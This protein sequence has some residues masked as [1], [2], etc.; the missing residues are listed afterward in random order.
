MNDV[1]LQTPAFTAT[2]LAPLADVLE[3]AQE[4]RV[5][6]DLPGVEPASIK[7][8]VENDTLSVSAERKLAAL[9]AG[10]GAPAERA[11]VV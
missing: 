11:A 2:G 4:Y 7:L 8:Q 9:A 10:R 1:A 5:A 3:A 6:I